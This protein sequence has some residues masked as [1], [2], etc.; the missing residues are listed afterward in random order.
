M[1][2]QH[3]VPVMFTKEEIAKI[4][5]WRFAHR[6]GSRSG[7]IRKLVSYGVWVMPPPEDAQVSVDPTA[8]NR[9]TDA[10]SAYVL[11]WKGKLG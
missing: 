8:I 6:I 5:D 1:T 11:E 9:A 10:I 7:A 3:R 2:R 4:D